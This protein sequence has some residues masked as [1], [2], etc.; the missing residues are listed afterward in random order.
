LVGGSLVCWPAH[1]VL[2]CALVYRLE[3]SKYAFIL[4][5]ADRLSAGKLPAACC[6]SWNLHFVCRLSGFS[7]VLPLLI[8]LTSCSA[9]P[10]P[11]AAM[12]S[13]AMLASLLR[14]S[15]SLLCSLSAAMLA[16]LLRCSLSA[17][18]LTLCCCAR[19][20]CCYARSLC[21]YVRFSAS[22]LTLSTLLSLPAAM[23]PAVFTTCA[24]VLT[25]CASFLLTVYPSFSYLYLDA[26]AGRSVAPSTQ[27]TDSLIY[28]LCFCLKFLLVTQ[29]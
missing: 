26:R 12:L 9:M 25:L 1:G 27:A 4:L 10:A 8:A 2:V 14:C 6:H 20:L 15:L 24:T 23:P 29:Y 28:A 7:L 19:S 17:A 11:S 21:S 18:M 3:K 22:M 16:S 5:P 13:A